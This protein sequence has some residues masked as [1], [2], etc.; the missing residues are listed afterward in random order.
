VAGI[1]H[2]FFFLPACSHFWVIA[3]KVADGDVLSGNP[4]DRFP[5][6]S[7]FVRYSSTVQ[8]SQP[9][10]V[11]EVDSSNYAA[12]RSF[13][14]G[15]E[16]ENILNDLRNVY[17]N[18]PLNASTTYTVFVWGFSPN[19]SVSFDLSASLSGS[20]AGLYVSMSVCC[21]FVC[22]FVVLDPGWL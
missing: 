4:L 12:A 22:L 21:L 1:H 6:N 11:A 3:M 10:I 19:P 2:I 16:A 7:S 8:V 15:S 17:V 14:L 20:V 9:Y 5:D 13:L 18:G